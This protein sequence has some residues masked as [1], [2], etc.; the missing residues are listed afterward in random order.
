M[1]DVFE[2]EP[3][4]KV[5]ELAERVTHSHNE[6]MWYDRPV[7]HLRGDFWSGDHAHA[8]PAVGGDQLSWSNVHGRQ[9]SGMFGS[10]QT[11]DESDTERFQAL[12]PIPMTG[13]GDYTNSAVWMRANMNILLEE[14]PDTFITI[15]YS[16]HDG[17]QLALPMD[18]EIPE[19]LAERIEGLWGDG[20]PSLDDDEVS[21]LENEILDED[22]DSW[23]ERDFHGALE[24][25]VAKSQNLDKYEI[26]LEEH[27]D[28]L[29][30]AKDME[31]RE[32]F[33]Q[34]ME[35][36]NTY[37]EFE[38]SESCYIRDLE[39]VVADTAAEIL[40]GEESNDGV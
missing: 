25:A 23:L 9:W 15:G 24:T 6:W 3:M 17:Q 19:H 35:A 7:E 16:S 14:Y 31:L 28:A 33:G 13:R 40:L 27:V 32:L 10:T 21:K 29:L 36:S 37:P 11:V 38:T 18:A 30:A 12:L 34:A 2:D 4:V 5:S 20:Y 26:D 1:S 39:T 22:W 8:E